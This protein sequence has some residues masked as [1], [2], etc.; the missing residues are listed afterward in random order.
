MNK[1]ATQKS[2]LLQ[3]RSKAPFTAD[4]LAGALAEISKRLAVKADNYCYCASQR[5]DFDHYSLAEDIAELLST[6]ESRGCA[7]RRV[8]SVAD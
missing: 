7:F 4:R 3:I 6:I 8:V 2:E 5:L 1:T